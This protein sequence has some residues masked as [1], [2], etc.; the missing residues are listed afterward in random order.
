MSTTTWFSFD[1]FLICSCLKLISP[2]AKGNAGWYDACTMD[3]DC[4]DPY[5]CVFWS[6]GV[7]VIQI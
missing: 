2:T 4:I 7:D 1:L 5:R 3:A 6:A